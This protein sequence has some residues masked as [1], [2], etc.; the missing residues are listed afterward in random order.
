MLFNTLP[1]VRN[2][3]VSRVWYKASGGLL[4]ELCFVLC[5]KINVLYKQHQLSTMYIVLTWTW[6]FDNTMTFIILLVFVWQF[7]LGMS[8]YLYGR[9]LL[10][11][12]QNIF[13]LMLVILWFIGKNDH[14]IAHLCHQ[15]SN[16]NWCKTH[17]VM[18]F[19]KS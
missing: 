14:G 2:S 10:I 11:M 13:I 16:D 18:M 9:I 17:R 4:G 1:H 6:L 15:P 12:I 8:L 5:F 3:D 19:T 7:V